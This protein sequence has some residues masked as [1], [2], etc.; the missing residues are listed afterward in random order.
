MEAIARAKPQSERLSN[1][2][3]ID[4]ANVMNLHDRSYRPRTNGAIGFFEMVK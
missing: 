1:V 4:V 3:I 2:L